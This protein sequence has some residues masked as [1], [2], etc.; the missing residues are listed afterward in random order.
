MFPKHSKMH[1]LLQENLGNRKERKQRIIQ[2]ED[3]DED[4][5]DRTAIQKKL[6]GEV[7]C[8]ILRPRILFLTTDRLERFSRT[9]S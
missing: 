6:F 5:D 8:Q 9:V 1:C 4:V 3:S 7:S 2:P